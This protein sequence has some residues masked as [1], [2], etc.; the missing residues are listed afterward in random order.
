MEVIATFRDNNARDYIFSKGSNLAGYKDAHNR[1]TCGIR[2]H[3]PAHLMGSFKT[4]ESLGNDL[5]REHRRKIR[6]YIK[7]DEAEED[8]YLHVKHDDDD[9]WLTF[10]PSE[11]KNE[12]SKKNYR[13][14]SKSSIHKAPERTDDR[15][16]EEEGDRVPGGNGGDEEME[17]GGGEDQ[18]RKWNPPPRN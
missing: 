2:L 11:A 14:I 3:I 7:F 12:L 16:E 6:K 5:K 18:P 10:S 8:L 15:R 9:S 4:L 13:K 17:Q 1:P